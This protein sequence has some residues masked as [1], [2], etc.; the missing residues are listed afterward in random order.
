MVERAIACVA[1]AL[2]LAGLAPASAQD[3]EQPERQVW[4]WF[5]DVNLR[6][7]LTQDLP[8]GRD[9][10]ERARLR[11]RAGGRASFGRWLFTASARGSLGTDDNDDNRMNF[12]NE[13]SDDLRADRLSARWWAGRGGELMLGKSELVPVLGPMVWDTDLRPVGVA[14][15]GS[16]PTGAWDTIATSASWVHPDHPLEYGSSS[17]LA[18]LQADWRIRPGAPTN[19]AATLSYLRYHDIEDL[20]ESGL[21]RTNRVEDGRY[22]SD[23][24]LLD[25]QLVARWRTQSRWPLR[26]TVD[27]VLNL[28]ADRDDEDWGGQL[29]FAAGSRT[30]RGGWELA[31]AVQR[32]QRDAVLA[33]FN[34]D[35]WWFHS[36]T[37]AT[38]GWLAYALRDDLWLRLS[39]SF[40]RRDDL[41]ETLTRTLF[42]TT[43]SF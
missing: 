27:S 30:R 25:L 42:D 37:R 21:A 7:E 24:E 34:S 29:I 9:D 33:A 39:T 8:G 10:L 1:V 2:L 38:R 28:G 40:E 19:G 22:A 17:R 5:G 20:V 43:W 12:D 3:P 15:S 32:I 14:W 13:K 11:A 23:F 4:T 16:W 36:A 41:T 31:L 6:G 18:T 35:D 26:L